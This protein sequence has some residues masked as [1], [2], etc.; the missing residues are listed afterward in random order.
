MSARESILNRLRESLA[1][2]D[3]RFPP[4]NPA[5]LTLDERMAVTEAKGDIP[6]LAE[7]F[8][9]ELEALHGSFEIVE[10]PTEARL[11]LLNRLIAWMNQEQFGRKGAQ[12]TTGQERMVLS[13]SPARLPVPGLA[14]ALADLQIELVAPATFDTVE[15]RDAVRFIRYGITGVEAAFAATGSMMFRSGI[16]THRIAGLLPIRH[17]ALIP[18]N[19]LYPTIEA[20]LATLRQE[21]RLVE[22][23]RESANWSMVTGPSKSA[24]IG[25]SLTL[26]VHGPKFVHAILFTDDA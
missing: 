2:P 1:R 7:R 9:S 18:T 15:A 6:Q 3:L 25:G 16:E 23:M 8:G 12:L 26:G 10:S 17:I 20:W 24:D 11:T 14:D 4:S 22:E 5:P 13:W 19:R 21:G